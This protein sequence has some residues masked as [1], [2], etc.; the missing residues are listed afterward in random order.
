MKSNVINGVSRRAVLG[1]IGAGLLASTA[2]PVVGF[3]QGAPIKIGFQLHRTGIGASYGRWYERT[4]QAAAKLINDG[5]GIG[6]RPVELVFEDDG[7]DP[8]RGAE[9]VEK[10]ASQA[11]CDVVMGTLFSH[12]VIGSAPRAGELK[13]PYLVCSEGYHVASG[14]LN[15]WT[16]QPGITDVRSQIASMAP[17]V[18]ANLGKKI[19][20]IFPDFAFGHDHRDFF[21]EAMKA[22]GGEVI[23]Q[24]AIPPTETSFTRYFPQIPTE[25]EV[26][27]HV[28]VGPAVLTFVKELGEFY[29]TGAKPKM[30]GFIDSLEAVDTATPGLEFLEGSH[31]WE[32]HNRV[33]PGDAG[34]HEAAYRAAVGVDDNG[35]SV[36]DAADV[37]T[38]S[39]M[40]STW[41][42]LFAIKAGMEAAGYTGPAD[43]QKF[44][45]AME[46]MS[47]LPYGIERPQG[48]KHFNGKTHQVFGVQNISQVQGGKL[49]RVH[50]TS[51]ADGA[52][53]DAVDYTTMAF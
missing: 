50:T 18:A 10:L 23:A 34:A 39:H 21:T 5:G 38:Y 30:F 22:R 40:F 41:E 15:R 17:W 14:M 16:L 48:A 29:G 9:V 37:A 26:L 35:A 19:T 11:G 52:Y 47:D 51:M 31:F 7:T 43:R 45:E 3:A 6:G 4:A 32:G 27:Y 25:T 8:K 46:A 28:M 1:G 2:L 53:P 12:V 13:V 24:I 20:M 44:V 33:K 49:V 36:S 42:T